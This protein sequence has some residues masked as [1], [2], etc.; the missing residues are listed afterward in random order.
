[1][2]FIAGLSVFILVGLCGSCSQTRDEATKVHK[3]ESDTARQAALSLA[4]KYNAAHDWKEQLNRL[5]PH[6]TLNVE[7]ALIRKDRRPVLLEADLVDIESYSQG[8]YRIT[9]QDQPFRYELFFEED[10]VRPILQD[11]VKTFLGRFAIVAV[12]QSIK[13]GVSTESKEEIWIASGWCKELVLLSDLEPPKGAA[14]DAPPASPSLIAGR[15]LFGLLTGAVC[16]WAWRREHGK[17]G[18]AI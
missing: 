1:M 11:R 16:V 13:K 18:K 17:T 4:R 10:S 14:V 15:S 8:I 12:I 3:N 5:G 2:R 9:F 7:E 6:Y